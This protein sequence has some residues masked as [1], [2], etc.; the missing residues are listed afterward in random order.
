MYSVISIIAALALTVEAQAAG[1]T[2]RGGRVRG[3]VVDVAGG[4]VARAF[5]RVLDPDS[6]TIV[7][8]TMAGDGGAFQTGTL[9][10]GSYTV[11]AWAGGFRAGVIRGVVVRNGEITDLGKIQ[12]GLAGCDA[13]GVNCD[14]FG[15]GPRSKPVVSGY[16]EVKLECRVDLGKGTIHCPDS[17]TNP[18]YGRT[19]D[20]QLTKDQAGIYLSPINGAASSAPNSSRVDCS[21]AK[22]SESR[23]RL[24]GLGPGYDICVRTHDRRFSHVFLE[25]DVE[26]GS[27]EIRL[28]FVTPK[29]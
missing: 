10:P 13:P 9:D 8:R 7:A 18:S 26:P 21:D 6:N 23:V 11:R 20:F 19:A 5:I 1:Q 3:L 29:R 24:D 25:D 2:V 15:I 22:F 17:D 12:L 4:G 28:Y 14:D 27:S 16:L